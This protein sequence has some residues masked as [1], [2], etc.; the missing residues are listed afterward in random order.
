M[1]DEERESHDSLVGV[2]SPANNPDVFGHEEQERFLCK[3]WASGRMHHAFLFDGPTGIGK[4]TLAFKFARHLIANPEARLAP[5]HFQDGDAALLHQISIGAHPQ[6]LHLT[7]PLDPKSLKFKTQLTIDETRKIGHFLSLTIPGHGWRIV[8]VDPV[9]DM[10]ASAA[11]ALLKNLEEPTARTVFVLIAQT[12]GRLLTTIRSRCLHLRFASL[13]DDAMR[14][15]LVNLQIGQDGDLDALIAHAGGSPRM[16]AMLA[17][18]GAL[19]IIKAADAIISASRFD[20]AAALKIGEVLN[21]RDSEPLF[22]LLNDHLAGRLAQSAANAAVSGLARADIL[23][24][25]HAQFSQQLG[26]AR[27]FNLDKRQFLLEALREI[28]MKL[29]A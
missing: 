4:S 1:S 18:G 28:H 11:N 17:N 22:L 13:D 29:A 27:G 26:I 23:A 5:D 19:D 21:T 20:A 16:A 24:T 2:P 9:N 3:A 6:V 10:N 7:R 25:Y 14:S 15:A 12:V 8:I